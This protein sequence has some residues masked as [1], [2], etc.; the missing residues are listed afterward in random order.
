MAVT[1]EP[2][3]AKLGACFTISV[4]RLPEQVKTAGAALWLQLT[5]SI[6]A[7]TQPGRPFPSVAACANAQSRTGLIVLASGV[8]PWDICQP[9]GRICPVLMQGSEVDMEEESEGQSRP[10][11]LVL[12]RRARQHFRRPCVLADKD[13]AELWNSSQAGG[14]YF[15]VLCIQLGGAC[16]T[17][18][19]P[20]C[21]RSCLPNLKTSCSP[22]SDLFVLT[23][24]LP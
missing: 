17:G 16:L 1:G 9:S 5:A 4:S 21:S 8:S 11:L 3:T 7:R 20:I 22:H 23:R 14:Q 2:L 15:V 6:Q 18:L 13:S 10:G 12:A 19:L 24:G